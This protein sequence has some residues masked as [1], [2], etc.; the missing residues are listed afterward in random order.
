[1]IEK[2]TVNAYTNIEKINSKVT[3]P[4]VL[5]RTTSQ[6][7]KKPKEL[8]RNKELGLNTDKTYHR[9]KTD[10]TLFANAAFCGGVF[11]NAIPGQS[12]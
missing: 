8:E 4:A 3:T 12:I 11:K 1:M 10:V 7:T 9:R 2:N 6:E 5:Y